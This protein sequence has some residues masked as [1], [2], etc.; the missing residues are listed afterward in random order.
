MGDPN[1]KPLNRAKAELLR[2]VD[3]FSDLQQFYIIF[4]NHEQKAFRI[5][6]TGK[7]IIFASDEN[8][9]LA[10]QF[11]DGIQAGGGTKHADALVLACGC[12]PTR[13]SCL[14]TAI[15]PTT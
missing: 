6:P 2:S 8:K 14:P 4:Y 5:E 13:F 3:A 12:I 1:N 7:R 9:R 10:N 15:R 11:V